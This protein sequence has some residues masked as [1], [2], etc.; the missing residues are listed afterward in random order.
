[1]LWSIAPSEKASSLSSF[2]SFTFLLCS[3][4]SNINVHTAVVQ[5]V[6]KTEKLSLP[7]F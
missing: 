2:L 7:V 1:M 6:E 5:Q 4:Q 3:F